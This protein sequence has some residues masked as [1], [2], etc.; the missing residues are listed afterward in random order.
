M[1][2]IRSYVMKEYF[3]PF[4]FGILIF[5]FIF[6]ASKMINITDMVINK[7]VGLTPVMQLIGYSLPPI[8]ILTIPMGVLLAN[9]LG[10]SR[11]SQDNEITALKANGVNI[12]SIILA[13]LFTGIL[14]SIAL[15]IFY[16]QALPAF[17]Y[18]FFETSFKI[19]QEKPSLE[20]REHA[21]NN[22]ANTRIYIN[23]IEP[24]TFAL[25]DVIISEND[26]QTSKFIQAEKGTTYLCENGSKLILKL[27]NGAIHQ[28]D[29][30]DKNKYQSLLFNTHNVVINLNSQATLKREKML[31]EMS[32][33]ELKNEISKYKTA[34][35]AVN[36]FLV[37]LYRRESL[38]FACIAFTL[39]AIPLGLRSKNKSK[40][41]SFGLSV[42]IIFAYYMLLIISETLSLRGTF[43]VALT[44]WMPNI[45]IG[46]IGA[47]LLFRELK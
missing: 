12:L 26:E 27:E 23:K 34:K 13:P 5:T 21:F 11:L 14:I 37:E 40:S 47:F 18:G 45:I 42:L 1:K 43:S 22:L 30:I 4:L 24:K 19:S 31:E 3:P 8:L 38:P 29:P 36:P 9:L 7:G 10:F 17:H 28:T 39:F 15:F 35:I 41:I 25:I 20:L 32:G 6:L 44:M 2:I 16:N 46:G 33:K